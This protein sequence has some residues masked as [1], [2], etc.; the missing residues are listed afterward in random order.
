[1]FAGVAE[2]RMYQWNNPQT[3]HVQLSGTPPTWYRGSVGGPRV[4]VYENGAL[5]DD[6]S[7]KVSEER[8]FDL[9][10][11]AFDE[12]ERRKERVVLKRLEEVARREAEKAERTLRRQNKREARLVPGQASP[13]VPDEPESPLGSLKE[14][15]TEA[16]ERVKS[17][18]AE[19]DRLDRGGAPE[20]RQ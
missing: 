11:A 16:V 2:A 10:E 4:L 12:A 5:V 18:I 3:G 6:T 14:I 7:L 19:F 17:I 1:M 15:G 8:A 20:S 13:N 9:R